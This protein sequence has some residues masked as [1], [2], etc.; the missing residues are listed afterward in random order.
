MT[1]LLTNRV[2][3][4]RWMQAFFGL[5]SGMWSGAVV[6]SA[7]KMRLFTRRGPV[8]RYADQVHFAYPRF[9]ALRPEDWFS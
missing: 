5:R 4:P 1:G 8:W 6:C 9:G 7:S 3:T 2:W